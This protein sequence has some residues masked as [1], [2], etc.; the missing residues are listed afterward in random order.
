[1]RPVV[2]PFQVVTSDPRVPGPAVGSLNLKSSGIMLRLV[3][4]FLAFQQESK[5]KNHYMMDIQSISKIWN[6][7]SEEQVKVIKQKSEEGEG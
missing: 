7:N 4:P 2:S 5:N 6:M 1:M 3:K